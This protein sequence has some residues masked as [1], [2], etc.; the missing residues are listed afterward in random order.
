MSVKMCPFVVCTILWR[1]YNIITFKPTEKTMETLF[2]RKERI[3]S[4]YDSYIRCLT[5]FP[6]L[7]KMDIAEACCESWEIEIHELADLVLKSD[8]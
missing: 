3:E 5:K 7:T 6:S 1:G 4:A 8:K 2:T